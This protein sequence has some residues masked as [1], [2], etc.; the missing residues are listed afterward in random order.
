MCDHAEAV[1]SGAGGA[2][3][4]SRRSTGVAAAGTEG[5][6]G[7]GAGCAGERRSDAKSEPMIRYT[8]CSTIKSWPPKDVTPP[9]AL[10]PHYL[11]VEHEVIDWDKPREF[12]ARRRAGRKDPTP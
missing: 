3:V 11:I 5:V 7:G 2:A 8:P 12:G 4:P 1:V 9:G 6:L 10:I